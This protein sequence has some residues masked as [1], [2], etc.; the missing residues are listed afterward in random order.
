MTDIINT[1]KQVLVNND[2]ENVYSSFDSLPIEAKGRFFTVIGIK[3]LEYSKPVYSEFTIYM[4]FRT[5][6]EIS[7]LAPLSTSIDKVWNYYKSKI[8]ESIQNIAG[9]N[10]CISDI[11]VKQDKN[12]SRFVLKVTISA[13]GIRK[14]ER[15][16]EEQEELS[17]E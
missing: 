4:P 13:D 15:E 5:E 9:L 10:T 2:A 11:S 1:I 12:I 8:K 14:I 6:I 3:K 16:Q 7:I 17:N